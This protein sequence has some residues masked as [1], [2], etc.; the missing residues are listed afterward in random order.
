MDLLSRFLSLTPVNGRIDERCRFGSPWVVEVGS[1]GVQEIPYHVLLAGEAVLEDGNGP[2]R[3]LTA[4]DVILFPTGAAHR[5]HDG[6][7][8]QPGPAVRRR[9]ITLTVVENGGSGPA[10]DLLCGR[11]LVGAMPD[12]LLREHLPARLVVST[13]SIAKHAPQREPDSVALD[14]ARDEAAGATRIA[15]IAGEASQIDATDG[16]AQAS[17]GTSADTKAGTSADTSAAQPT[18]AGSRLARIVALMREE[19]VDESPGSECLI[20][21]LSA[22]LFALTLRF[23]SEAADAPRGL[24]ALAGQPRLQPALSAM[25]EAPGKPWTLDQFAA[26]CHMSRATFVR[27]FQ[28]AIGRSATDMLTEVRLT[29][30]GRALLQ[31]SE[32]VAEI[33]ATIGY[34]SEA[35]FQR[36]F[37][38]HLGVTPARWRATGGDTLA[39]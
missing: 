30:A 16:D 4:G 39:R 35:A 26:L 31:T 29:I 21:Y 22:A 2:P 25:F 23:A 7:G 27:Q 38:R 18:V 14:A 15:D 9:N 36:V 17:V 11:F 32:S 12:R 10:A 33:G 19:A 13:G 37:K 20:N 3:T 8:V 24:L 28:E 5:I 6:S 1:A 34:Q